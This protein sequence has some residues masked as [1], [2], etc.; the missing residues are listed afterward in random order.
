MREPKIKNKYHLKPA[1]IS[2]LV[3]NDRSKIKEPLF[4]RNDVINAWC[5]S[6]SI[7]TDADRILYGLEFMISRIITTK[8]IIIALVGAA[9]V[10]IIL[11]SFSI[12]K[13]LKQKKT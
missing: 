9:W 6:K 1:D 10:D 5:I 8:Y 7:G 12:I 2:R 3:V 13:K 4:W 11:K